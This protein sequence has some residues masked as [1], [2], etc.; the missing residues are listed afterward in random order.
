MIV[1]RVMSGMLLLF[2]TIPVIAASEPVTTL[3]IISSIK[4]NHPKLM[5]LSAREEQ[6]KLGVMS[7]EGAF[8]IRVQQSTKI[9]TS[10]FYDGKYLS[11]GISKPLQFMGGTFFSEYRISDGRFPDYDGQFDTRNGG[12]ASIGISLSLMRNRDIDA[13]RVAIDNA[14][15]GLEEWNAQK[16]LEMNELLYSGLTSY[17]DWHEA[18]LRFNTINQLYR[19]TLVRGE[20]IQKRVDKGDLAT[21]ALTEFHSILLTRQTDLQQAKQQIDKIRESVSFYYRDENGAMIDL[22]SI[23]NTPKDIAW[24]FSMDETRITQLENSI[25]AHPALDALLYS[26]EQA[27]NRYQLSKNDLLPQLDIEGRIAR[28]IGSGD[29]SLDMLDSEIGVTFSVPIGRTTA[30]AE[31]AIAQQKIR[32]LQYELQ[33]LTDMLKQDFRQSAVILD[34]MNEI[35]DIYEQQALVAEE[36]LLQE[37]KRFNLGM[38]DL[39][40]LNERETGALEAKLKSIKANIDVLKQQLFTLYLTVNINNESF[41]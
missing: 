4:E 12:E 33:L 3:K 8:D 41:Q 35:A 18:S 7:A 14:K 1:P 28:D 16:R 37:Q 6:A 19:T 39:F 15:L 36:L 21:I 23:Q 24:P 9:K 22:E 30:N 13:R 10:G 31:K 27:R 5:T 29:E 17:L 34:N 26:I 32:E 2:M 40:L 38:S 25:N 20:G 11:Q